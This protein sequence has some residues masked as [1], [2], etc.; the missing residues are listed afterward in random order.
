MLKWMKPL[1]WYLPHYFHVEMDEIAK[2]FFALV[3]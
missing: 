3:S 1:I 2:V